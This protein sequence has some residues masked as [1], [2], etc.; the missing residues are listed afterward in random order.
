[1][2]ALAAFLTKAAPWPPGPQAHQDVTARLAVRVWPAG[3]RGRVRGVVTSAGGEEELRSGPEPQQSFY[4]AL[5][6]AGMPAV[7]GEFSVVP[8][9]QVIS[10]AVLAGISDFIL[11]FDR[12]TGREAWQTA[13]LR[14]A[15]AIVQ[16]RRPE[17]CFFSAW[18]FHL[19]PDGTWQ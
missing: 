13:A 9:H 16:P 14:H 5:Q 2:P 8:Q 10:S 12:I 18:D 11:S 1:M 7:P 17:V 3:S 19:P 6:D 4:V 15:P